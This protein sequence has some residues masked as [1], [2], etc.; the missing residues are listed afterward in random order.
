MILVY[1]TDGDRSVTVYVCYATV[2]CRYKEQEKNIVFLAPVPP[3]N[4]AMILTIL[5]VPM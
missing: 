5:Y 4:N 3:F 2:K 1:G